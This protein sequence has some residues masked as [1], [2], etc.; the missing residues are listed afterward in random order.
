M[1]K[2][3]KLKILAFFLI[4]FENYDD[5]DDETKKNKD[6]AIEYKLG[7]RQLITFG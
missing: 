7:G 6:N 4:K 3:E 1:S 5:E 2:S